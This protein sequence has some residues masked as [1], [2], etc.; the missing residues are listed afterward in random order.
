LTHAQKTHE[1][2]K[3]WVRPPLNVAIWTI[4]FGWIDPALAD[5]GVLQEWGLPFLGW[6][7]GI[8]VFYLG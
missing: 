8:Y 3:P 7:V 4:L 5:D 2:K 6:G 1:V